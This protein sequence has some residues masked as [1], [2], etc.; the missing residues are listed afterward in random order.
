MRKPDPAPNLGVLDTL[1][2]RQGRAVVFEDSPHS[3]AAAT[4]ARMCTWLFPT[5]SLGGWVWGA[6]TSCWIRWR[7]Y[8]YR[9][10]WRDSIGAGSGRIEKGTGVA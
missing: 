8:R 6:P 5:R 1:A 4:A 2:V 9:S 7:L 10:C 3:I